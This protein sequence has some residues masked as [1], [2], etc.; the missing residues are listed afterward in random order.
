MSEIGHPLRRRILVIDDNEAIH[1]D[2]RKILETPE[3][4]SS[5]TAAKAALFGFSPAAAAAVRLSFV[6]DTAVQGQ[7]GF[8]KVEEALR[9][10]D[11]YA[12]AFVDMRMPPGWDGL[13]TI[14]NIW[15]IDDDIQIVICT[16]FSDCSLDEITGELGQRDRLLLLKKPFDNV[17]VLQLANAL[18][19]KWVLKRQ[20]AMKME[21]LERLVQERTAEIEYALLHDKLTD[22]PNRTLL[23]ERLNAA[24]ERR[25]RHPDYKFAILF[26]DFDRFK[27]IN[28]SLGH[29][30]GDLLLIEVAERLRDSLRATDLVSHTSTAA[31]LGGDEFIVLLEDLREE[32]DA[33]RVAARLLKVL[34]E[35]YSL[36]E[37]KIHVTLSIGIATSDR[38][39][40]RAGD[41]IRDADTAMYRAKA[42]GRA[43]FVMF[44]QRMHEEVA[45]RMDLENGLRQAVQQADFCLH[46]QPIV[47]LSTGDLVA[48]EALV[49]W[50]HPRRGVINASELIPIAED[51]GLILPLSLWVLE[52]ACRQLKTWRN[53]YPDLRRLLMSVNLSRKQL[54]DSELVERI[55]GIVRAAGLQP[56]DL[57]LEITESTVFDDPA[58]ARQV[59]QRLQQM[60][61]WLHLDDFGTG[62][63]SLSCLYQFPLSGLKIDRSFMANVTER[64]ERVAMLEAIVTMARAL[65]LLVIGEGVE[66]AEQAALLARLKVDQAQG[67]YYDRPRD[68]AAAETFIKNHLAGCAVS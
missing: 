47:D 39:Y 58:T 54:I 66:T 18:S 48:F 50:H 51:T 42:A 9:A 22:L 30:M 12:V 44:D 27:L 63:S 46:Y 62:Q 11:P 14:R 65:R 59:F 15:R 6:L 52:E 28:D 34:A 67:Y 8:R 56:R 3:R 20:A 13:Q 49:R 57:V 5:L 10:G 68:A 19:E 26:L 16:A 2:F 21:A 24:I 61:V 40:Q 4:T 1:A 45:A 7:D 23:T 25:R 55:S 35:P 17:E 36:N 33:A 64:P 60:G 41:M 53:R 37:Q 32:S 29:E 31:R 38:E 43:R